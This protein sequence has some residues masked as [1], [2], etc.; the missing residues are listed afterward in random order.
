MYTYIYIYVCMY[1]Y[2]F[3]YITH[4]YN[5]YI[6]HIYIYR[7]R[8]PPG[9]SCCMVFL[10]KNSLFTKVSEMI[11]SHGAAEGLGFLTD[12]RRL[13]VGITRA[14]SF[15]AT[16]IEMGLFENRVYSQL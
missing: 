2:I 7:Y 3:S 1:I 10:F 9:V 16:G 5:I 12:H 11:A 15:L 13:N 8:A 4:T 6:Y 14:K